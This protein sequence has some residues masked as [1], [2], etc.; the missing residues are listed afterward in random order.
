MQFEASPRLH[1]D[2]PLHNRN[3]Q[4]RKVLYTMKF[5]LATSALLATGATAHTIFTQL[6]VNGVGQGHLKGVRVPV[7][8]HSGLVACVCGLHNAIDI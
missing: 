7:K 2:P 4:E 6:H 3:V 5:S 8:Y 1:I